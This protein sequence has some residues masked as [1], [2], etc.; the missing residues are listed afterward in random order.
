[1]N[2][3]DA[4]WLRF[5]HSNPPKN[6]ICLCVCVEEGIFFVI[7]SKPY[8]A[9]PADSQITIYPEE[10]SILA[11]TSFL[12]VSKSYVGFSPAEIARGISR[13]VHH[14]S[15]SARAKIKHIV[16]GQGYLIERVKKKVLQNL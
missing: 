11:H 3:G 13:G 4:L 14:L 1:L 2:P 12:D 5:S 15:D 10:L 16:S 6:K 7:S 9:A 8:K